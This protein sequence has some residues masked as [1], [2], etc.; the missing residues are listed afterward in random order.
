VSV[1]GSCDRQAGMG[2]G[3][4][5]ASC[6]VRRTRS[7]PGCAAG[8]PGPASAQQW[9]ANPTALRLAVR[10]SVGFGLQRRGGQPLAHQ[11]RPPGVQ[12]GPHR[13]AAVGGQPIPQQPGLP[14]QEPVQLAQDLDEGLGIVVARATVEAAPPPPPPTPSQRAAAIQAT[15]AVDRLHSTPRPSAGDGLEVMG[16][17]AGWIA[18]MPASPVGPM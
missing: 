3:T 2:A 11:P 15:E 9:L 10:P 4:S 13:S 12:P 1:A 6:G 14:A 17:H 7:M 8:Q 5:R 16:R 18:P